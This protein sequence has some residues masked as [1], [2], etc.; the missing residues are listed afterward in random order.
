MTHHSLALAN[1]SRR[2]PSPAPKG[3]T[4]SLTGREALGTQNLT[5]TLSSLTFTARSLRVLCQWNS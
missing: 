4:C 5:G 2:V 1:H 3:P